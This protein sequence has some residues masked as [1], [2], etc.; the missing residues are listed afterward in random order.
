MIEKRTKRF[1]VYHN[2]VR[3]SLVTGSDGNSK[4]HRKKIAFDYSEVKI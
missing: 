4:V 3:L 1:S 2:N